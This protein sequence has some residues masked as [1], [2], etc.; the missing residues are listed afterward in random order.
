MDTGQ[1]MQSPLLSQPQMRPF[2]AKE[3]PAEPSPHC[4]PTEHTVV[5]PL[6]FVLGCYLVKADRL[7]EVPG[8]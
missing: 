7:C 3:A 6:S 5:R 2:R 4:R 8:V 1:E